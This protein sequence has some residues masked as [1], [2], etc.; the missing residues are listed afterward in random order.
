MILIL[1]NNTVKKSINKSPIFRDEKQLIALKPNT[2][3]YYAKDL[4]I[5]NLYV[6]IR[7]RKR[8]YNDVAKTFVYRYS[9]KNKIYQ[10]SIGTYPEVTLDQAREKSDEYNAILNNE[11][12][13]MM[14][15]H[16]KVY[17]QREKA[18]KQ[19]LA[20]LNKPRTFEEITHEWLSIQDRSF[21]TDKTKMGRIKRH[22]FPLLGNRLVKT[23]GK[24]DFIECI[25]LIQAK[26]KIE[27][28]RRVFSLAREIMQF[29]LNRDYIQRNV[30]KEIE[31]A[32]TFRTVQVQHYRTIT[33]PA[34]L[35]YLLLAIEEYP[36]LITR[37]ALKASALLFLR[38]GNIRG[39]KWEY[40]DTNKRL[41]T[42][43]AKD[44]KM[45]SD[46]VVPISNQML[47]VLE[48]VKPL[49]CA[50]IYVFPSDIS[51]TK[52]MSE[53]TL[54]YA[55]KR[56]GFGEEM[57]FHGFRATASTLL[58]ENT[59][60]HKIASEVIELCLDHKE[61]NRVKASYN[62]SIRLQER[63]ELMQ[64]WSDYLDEIREGKVV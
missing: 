45:K 44:M 11:E 57:V 53:N 12:N 24:R 35:R 28:S 27:T 38:S 15:I 55:I 60:N 48:S 37:Y 8:E 7:D 23:L 1:R 31:F 6:A 51:K 9:F 26:G 2:H 30:L 32:K 10:I 34:K 41:I 64:W 52:Q 39:M 47:E 46:F 3:Q 61:R 14:G 13:R 59:P 16:P 50:S 20:E 25:E 17:L 19:R 43:P 58:H 42:F 62:H 54:N 56:M 5:N 36:A 22:L 29:A 40:G 18:E 49:S 63:R 33:D 21:L 4:A